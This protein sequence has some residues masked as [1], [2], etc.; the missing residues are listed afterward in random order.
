MESNKDQCHIRN[1]CTIDII[2][3][4]ILH[5][6]IG[7]G[8]GPHVSKGSDLTQGPLLQNLRGLQILEVDYIQ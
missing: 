6:L 8:H 4:K 2:T 5:I 1:H 3:V 7:T